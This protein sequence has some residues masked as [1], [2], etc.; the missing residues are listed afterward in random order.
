LQTILVALHTLDTVCS[1][2]ALQPFS[3]KAINNAN[4][5]FNFL[6]PKQSYSADDVGTPADVVYEAFYDLATLTGTLKPLND[7]YVPVTMDLSD[8]V[9]KES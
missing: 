1:T 7:D 3:N 5:F 9:K 2:K 4:S 8:H 6:R